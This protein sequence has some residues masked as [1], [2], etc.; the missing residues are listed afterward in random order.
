MTSMPGAAVPRQVSRRDILRWSGAGAVLAAA[1]LTGCSA[2]V[3]APSTATADRLFLAGMFNAADAAYLRILARD[4]ANIH[5]LIQRGNIALLANQ[6]AQAQSLL[7]RALKLAPGNITARQLL[8]MAFYRADAFA[9]AAPL[10]RDT[11]NRAEAALLASFGSRKPYDIVG[12]GTATVPFVAAPPTPLPP[13]RGGP[14]RSGPQPP[15]HVVE[16][17]S[18]YIAVSV[19]G[20]SPEPFGI[21]T[22]TT[23]LAVTAGLASRARLPLF[24]TVRGT[25][26]GGRAVGTQLARIDSLRLGAIELRNVPGRAPAAI[27]DG[28]KGDAQAAAGA[29]VL[30]SDILCHFLTTLDYPGKTLTLRQKSGTAAQGLAT[31]ARAQGWGVAAFWLNGYSIEVQGAV[32]GHGPM[33]LTMDSGWPAQATLT[34]AAVH[35]SGVHPDTGRPVQLAGVGGAF[36]A[37]PFEASELA[38]GTVT[39]HK[40]QGTT[41]PSGGPATDFTVAG[42]V[43]EPFFRPYAVTIDTVGMRLF[44]ARATDGQ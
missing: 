33:L 41:T 32:N 11:G 37:Y 39:E 18:A 7:T 12:P 3:S 40:V 26:A 22:G 4:Q 34:T 2:A 30:G 28:G 36:T 16:G 21:D 19:N 1:T 44:L 15:P 10:Y 29:N 38:L 23:G 5:A 42:S 14:A 43:G 6:P 9:E 31:S 17:P 20:L 27:L 25:A 8:G 35:A 13:A 24:G